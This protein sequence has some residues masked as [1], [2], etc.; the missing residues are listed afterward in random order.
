MDLLNSIKSNYNW[1]NNKKV[2]FTQYFFVCFL[3]IYLFIFEYNHIL[4]LHQSVGL[5]LKSD[6]Q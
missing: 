3:F 2:Y 4:W 6:S 5:L 1:Q